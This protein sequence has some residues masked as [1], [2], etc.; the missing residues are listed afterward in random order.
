MK[1]T[2]RRRRTARAKP[3]A[4]S[5]M[6]QLARDCAGVRYRSAPKDFAQSL[7]DHIARTFD[8]PVKFLKRPGRV[9]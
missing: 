3:A 9:K 4:K 8:V 2:P 1:K 5:S 7:I 6:E